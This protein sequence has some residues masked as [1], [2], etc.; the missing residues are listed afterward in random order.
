MAKKM[1]CVI[2]MHIHAVLVACLVARP[3]TPI[4]SLA[5]GDYLH[6][7]AFRDAYKMKIDAPHDAA[8]P[9]FLWFYWRDAS[10]PVFGEVLVYLVFDESDEFAS[11]ASKRSSAWNALARSTFGEQ[12]LT[13]APTAMPDKVRHLFGHYYVVRIDG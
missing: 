9:Q 5:P 8:E 3:L 7:F 13:I 4:P 11:A 6:Y 10:P 12:G 2:I 1:A